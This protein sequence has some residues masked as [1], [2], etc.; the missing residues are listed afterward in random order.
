MKT[1]KSVIRMAVGMAVAAG[2][3][4]GSIGA[5]AQQLSISR[6]PADVISFQGVPGV[7]YTIQTATNM[8]S[9][10]WRNL[11]TL[12][13]TT[14]GY[15][16]Y[17]NVP[18]A[19]QT[20]YRTLRGGLVVASLDATS[21]LTGIVRISP[22]VQT[23]N[24]VLGVI[25]L[26][27]TGTAGTMQSLS[28]DLSVVTGVTNASMLFDNIQIR[29]AGVTYSASEILATNTAP[30]S[31]TH[32]SARFTNLEIP[33]SVDESVPVMV[34]ANI[35]PD[36]EGN[37][38]GSTVQVS[39]L[40]SGTTGGSQNNPTVIDQDY[41][42]MGVQEVTVT[43]N[44]ITMSSAAVMV[45]NTTATR[46]SAIVNNTG[47]IGYAFSFSYTLAAD[48]DPVYVSTDPSLALTTETSSVGQIMLASIIANS[49]AGDTSTAFMISPGESRTFTMTGGIFNDVGAGAG[50]MLWVKS[51]SYGT[52]LSALTAHQ[53]TSGLSNLRITVQ[54]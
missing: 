54:F 14:S 46:G 31:V 42:T 6:V 43:G 52:S 19:A 16:S 26:K 36:I 50:N 33:L 38:D 49:G 35:A 39:L 23:A 5:N 13:G 22:A 2:L 27:S 9:G 4:L 47:V 40:A 37:L 18:T 3:T 45:S 17:T 30:G 20:F 21:P 12:A 41:S 11:A 32:V 15:Q 28:L 34:L 1:G 29:V 48:T 7:S 44:V 24:V 8:V 53:I 25:D 10:I 51:L